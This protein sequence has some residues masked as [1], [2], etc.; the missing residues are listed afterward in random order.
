MKKGLLIALAVVAVLLIVPY[1]WFKGAQNAFVAGDEAVKSAWGDVQSTYQR[2]SDLI[3]NLVET[4]KGFATHEK[5][6]L[7]SVTEARSRVG[8]VKVDPQNLTA[9]SVKKFQGAQGELSSALSRLL[10]VAENY[11]NL[12]ANQNFLDLQSQLE[13]TE[14]RINVARSR[15]NEAAKAYNTKIRTFPDSLIANMLGFAQR[16]YF[17][18]EAA[19]QSAPKV[20]FGKPN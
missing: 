15:F 13:G 2:R 11:P 18:A 3:P 12:K 14:N 1:M 17:E 16:P 5:E 4:V 7:V 20:N 19:A 8:Q 9:D 6:I 10:V